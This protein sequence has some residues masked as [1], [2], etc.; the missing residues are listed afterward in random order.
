M[1]KTTIKRLKFSS[2][3]FCECGTKELLIDISGCLYQ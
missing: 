3:R 2:F 1:I